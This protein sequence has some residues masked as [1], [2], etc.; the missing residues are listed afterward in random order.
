MRL[1][2]KIGTVFEY[3][4]TLAV[5]ELK[6]YLTEVSWMKEILGINITM[7]SYQHFLITFLKLMKVSIYI[8]ITRNLH[9]TYSTYRIKKNNSDKYLEQLLR[10]VTK[11]RK[12][13]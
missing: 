10:N 13:V 1:F 12:F 3:L 7:T 9:Q 11:S 5:F 2:R 4:K 8:P 6:I